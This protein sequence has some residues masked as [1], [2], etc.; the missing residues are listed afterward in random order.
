MYQVVVIEIMKTA[1]DN[2][3]NSDRALTIF[4]SVA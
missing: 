3:L 1:F 4:L 2:S